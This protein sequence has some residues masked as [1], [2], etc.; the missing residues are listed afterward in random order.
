MRRVPPHRVGPFSPECLVPDARP[1]APAVTAASAF[2]AGIEVRNIAI[3]C[4]SVR[5]LRAG[6]E[7]RI[8]L[9]R[10]IVVD[11]ATAARLVSALNTCL[12]E[13][14][15]RWCITAPGEKPA[16]VSRAS[17]PS[18]AEPAAAGEKAALAFCTMDD[19]HTPHM[20]ERS[21]RLTEPTLAANHFLLS[22]NR[23]S[24]KTS[25]RQ[26]TLGLCECMAMPVPLAQQHLDK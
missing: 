21:V 13:Y 11:R 1:N 25:F 17:T 20:Y 18:H 4:G 16:I 15:S 6:D 26:A 2:R 8:D 14:E 23:Q 19:L 12:R 5:T 22:L 9:A 7:V 3:D 24:V 10:R